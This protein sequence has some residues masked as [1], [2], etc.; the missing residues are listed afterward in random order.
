MK[1][2]AEWFAIIAGSVDPP[3]EVYGPSGGRLA[4][5]AH[6]ADRAL[7][8]RTPRR[9]PSVEQT[10]RLETPRRATGA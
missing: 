3:V 1:V 4:A 9:F 5:R 6:P 8:R 2:S 10:G 7:P